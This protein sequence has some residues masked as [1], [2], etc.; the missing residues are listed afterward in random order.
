[1]SGAELLTED[2][3]EDCFVI[4]TIDPIPSNKIK[5]CLTDDDDDDDCF[6]VEVKEK[7]KSRK[8]KE[9]T[10]EALESDT[11]QSNNNSG[12]E[13]DTSQ[14]N[15]N[16]G[17]E[18]DPSQPINNSG[19]N[20]DTSQTINNSGLEN[21]TNQ[22]NNNSE[23]END[24]N[25]SNSNSGQ[26]NDTSQTIN[27]SGQENDTSQTINNSG[28]ENDTSQTIN[29]SGQE[30][31]T[32][33]TIN[34][35]GQDNDTRQPSRFHYMP[36]RSQRIY[37]RFYYLP[38]RSERLRKKFLCGRRKR[39][40]HENDSDNASTVVVKSTRNSKRRI[41]KEQGKKCNEPKRKG[42]SK[43]GRAKRG[44]K[45]FTLRNKK[46]DKWA[47]KC[48]L[49][50]EEFRCLIARQLHELRHSEMTR[51]RPHVILKKSDDI[52][53]GRITSCA[54]I[55]K[56]S[57]A[58]LEMTAKRRK[59]SG[60][61]KRKLNT[62]NQTQS[63][64]NRKTLGSAA[65]QRNERQTNDFCSWKTSTTNTIMNQRPRNKLKKVS[66]RSA[67]HKKLCASSQENEVTKTPNLW[68][69]TS[70]PCTVSMKPL[71][72]CVM[73][74]RPFQS[75]THRAKHEAD[76][77]WMMYSCPCGYKFENFSLLY[78]HSAVRHK[79]L[80]N[81]KYEKR[82]RLRPYFGGFVHREENVK[83]SGSKHNVGNDF[84][85]HS[86]NNS[87]NFPIPIDTNVRE[88]HYSERY[89]SENSNNKQTP[90]CSSD[91]L[92]QRSNRNSE[93]SV[94]SIV[95][96]SL[97]PEAGN[98]VTVPDQ[99][100]DDNSMLEF[101]REEADIEPMNSIQNCVPDQDHCA[102]GNSPNRSD[103][104]FRTAPRAPRNNQTRFQ[105]PMASETVVS[106]PLP[107]SSS[108]TINRVPVMIG[109][110]QI[111]VEGP[112]PMNMFRQFSNPISVT[113]IKKLL[114]SL[115]S[116][117]WSMKIENNK[118]PGTCSVR[119]EGDLVSVRHIVDNSFPRADENCEKD[120][121]KSKKDGVKRHVY[122]RKKTPQNIPVTMEKRYPICPKEFENLVSQAH[123]G[124]QHKDKR[125]TSHGVDLENYRKTNSCRTSR[126]NV[127][128]SVPPATKKR[129]KRTLTCLETPKRRKCLSK[130]PLCF[131]RF[132][133]K[134][135]RDKHVRNHDK[136]KYR[137]PAPCLYQFIDFKTFQRHYN[138]R[139][140]G[141]LSIKSEK[142]FRLDKTMKLSVAVDRYGIKRKNQLS[143]RQ[144]RC[145]SPRTRNFVGN[146]TCSLRVAEGQVK[147][148]TRV[149]L[150]EGTIPCAVE[151]LA[152]NTSFTKRCVAGRLHRYR[153]TLEQEP[154]NSDVQVPGTVAE[155]NSTE[156][157]FR[158]PRSRPVIELDLEDVQEIND[159]SGMSQ[160]WNESA[161]DDDHDEVSNEITE[162]IRENRNDG[163]DGRYHDYVSSESTEGLGEMDNTS[164]DDDDVSSE[165][166]VIMCRD[167]DK[168]YEDEDAFSEN[169]Q[170]IEKHDD[171]NDEG[172]N[173]NA[174][175]MDSDD[176][177]NDEDDMYSENTE[178]II[179][180][181]NSEGDNVD[182]SEN[183]VRM[184]TGHD[185]NNED[186]S[187]ENT[188][189]K[190]DSDR[191]DE[192]DF[193]SENTDEITREEDND[194]SNG[195]DEH[196]GEN[197]EEFRE[198][199]D[200]N[201]SSEDNKPLVFQTSSL[202]DDCRYYNF[203]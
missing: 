136:M 117:K 164:S 90:I 187:S 93:I 107:N 112:I 197:I 175:V 23:L 198:D 174:A 40:T 190:E 64:G 52:N 38:R 95:P 110:D 195:F 173:E 145:P 74:R 150:E 151:C 1:M 28:Q 171:N 99:P 170:E 100:V 41:V 56:S 115:T 76:H 58:G 188:E 98:F 189:K 14:S 9:E 2:D 84:Q 176:E 91:N 148:N 199:N 162:E 153:L 155:N 156:V 33:Q 92:A 104:N 36:R 134:T 105:D 16:P 126:G 132:T 20:N 160:F 24:K 57:L 186:V 80:L 18:N 22:S 182:F 61:Q 73:C 124:A 45:Q 8:L 196:S 60:K 59:N 17:V 141:K 111:I 82:R 172:G 165:N 130:C 55:L 154:L 108:K 21:E 133:F 96:D 78:R 167:Y 184:Y 77:D 152:E 122:K 114:N 142:K 10:N 123:R 6:V 137:C 50:S 31:D 127:K 32:S 13:N 149:V 88:F 106:S 147:K 178:E 3:E 146:C 35:S 70:D 30:T 118:K 69:N 63:D 177:R 4:A 54:Q 37:N 200:R 201:E 86:V 15:N 89:S 83:A 81:D 183:M 46:N 71:S 27:N 157:D 87:A 68:G 85:F 72:I 48:R 109:K 53:Y 168:R 202:S 94:L 119:I 101:N 102:Q 121:T 193:S 144:E 113:E 43:Q 116:G 34:N 66:E 169:T 97:V 75:E 140:R 131:R 129:W 5:N 7:R 103:D 47:T 138:D 25:Q 12:Q 163:N 125:T 181:D 67:D 191:N 42:K 49:C 180:K 128:D 185:R 159:N 192:D 26:D 39:Y 65:K 19:Q 11:N 29:N 194:R 120:T 161:N 44:N 51:K 62:A 79:E 143:H 139:H 158:R 179:E 166:T 135:V 203:R